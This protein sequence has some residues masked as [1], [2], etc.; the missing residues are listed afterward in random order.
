MAK[1]KLVFIN[2]TGSVSLSIVDWCDVLQYQPRPNP[3]DWKQIT[4][5]EVYKN[6]NI[7]RDYQL[8]GL[9]WLS[10]SYYNR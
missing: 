8:E 2:C 7:L 10:F 9:N 4:E 1:Y 3:K 6:N 5:T